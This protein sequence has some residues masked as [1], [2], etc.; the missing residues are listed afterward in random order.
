MT[1]SS[2]GIERGSCVLGKLRGKHVDGVNHLV[3]LQRV[4]KFVLAVERADNLE[5]FRDR[6]GDRFGI[7]RVF[8]ARHIVGLAHLP[9]R[10]QEGRARLLDYGGRDA[11]PAV[12]MAKRILEILLHQVA[13]SARSTSPREFEYPSGSSIHC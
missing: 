11:F 9:Q 5:K 1:Q 3:A 7:G 4:E 6:P 13:G 8:R 2:S 12:P 10:I